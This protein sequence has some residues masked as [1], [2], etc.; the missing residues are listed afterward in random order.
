MIVTDFSQKT[1]FVHPIPF[2]ENCLVDCRPDKMMKTGL[3]IIA[4]QNSEKSLCLQ[5]S[6]MGAESLRR[7]PMRTG[8]KNFMG[9][10]FMLFRQ[11]GKRNRVRGKE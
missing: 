2:K 1:V 5:K 9:V 3:W 8:S 10:R 4:G 6:L 7:S 11:E